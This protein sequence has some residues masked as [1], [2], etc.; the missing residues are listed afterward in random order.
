MGRET[1]GVNGAERANQKAKEGYT[2]AHRTTTLK[3][4][5]A[6]EALIPVIVGDSG[7]IS[8]K[9]MS[10]A[11]MVRGTTAYTDRPTDHGTDRYSYRNREF[12]LSSQ[13]IKTKIMTP[14]EGPGNLLKIKSNHRSLG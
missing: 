11:M 2:K 6:M 14:F 4:V 10:V 3:P 13:M 12:S 5:S 1:A 9:F 7:L 8:D